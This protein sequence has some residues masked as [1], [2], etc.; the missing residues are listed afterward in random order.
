ML[1]VYNVRN[2]SHRKRERENMAFQTGVVMLS[3]FNSGL[4]EKETEHIHRKLN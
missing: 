1:S 2:R 4:C 3:R